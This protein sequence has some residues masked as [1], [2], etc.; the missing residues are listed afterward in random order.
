MNDPNELRDR[1]IEFRRRLYEDH[2][3]SAVDA[4]L[5][6]EFSSHSPM[7]PGAGREAYKHFVQ[8]LYTGVP[9]LHAS[10]QHVLVEGEELMAMTQWEATHTGLF[11]G[12]PAT[13]KRLTFATADRYQIKDGFLFRHWDVV[14]RLRASVALGLLQELR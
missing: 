7:I 1:F 9:D 10:Q 11:L 13:G 3:L 8:S 12:V 4:Y 6:P 14:D 2:D 5:H